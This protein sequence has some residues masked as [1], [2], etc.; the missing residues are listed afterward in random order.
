MHVVNVG[1]ETVIDDYNELFLG[2]LVIGKTVVGEV[3]IDN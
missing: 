1:F 2:I 3:G